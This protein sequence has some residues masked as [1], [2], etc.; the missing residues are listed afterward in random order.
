A[1]PEGWWRK[2][3]P[4]LRGERRVAAAAGSWME[5]CDQVVFELTGATDPA[6][7]RRSRCA[8][9]HKAMWHQS[10]GG[11]PPAKFLSRLDPRLG[12]L[13]ERLYRDT[14]TSDQPAGTLSAGWAAKLG[15][16][17]NTIVAM[18]LVDAHAG[19]VGGKISPRTLVKVM[20]T[21]TCDMM[22]AG[23][24]EI[25]QHLVKGICG[26]VD[27][28]VVPGMVGLEAGQ[29]GFGDLLAWFKDLVTEPALGLIK[30]SGLLDEGTRKALEEEV[31]EGILEKLSRAAVKI[32]VLETAPVALDWIHGRR[33]PD[34]NP[35]LKAALMG[36][37]AGTDAAWIY[38][39]LVES[40]CFGSRKIIERLREEGMSIEAVIAMGGVAQKSR[41][42]MQTMADVLG[43]P[44]KV[45]SSDQAPALGA[46]IFGAV[47]SG[48][49]PNTPSAIAAMGADFDRVYEPDST[50]AEVYEKLYRRYLEFGTFVEGS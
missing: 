48:I 10:W 34:A 3:L 18:G 39:A 2:S 40:L 43:M 17:Q 7:F 9:G 27:G 14:Y 26:Q 21:S 23:Y 12:E 1:W 38:R 24:G 32:P 19:A 50:N 37:Q 47:A 36:L 8:A 44:I 41:L 22:V 30:E 4:V 35:S 6:S 28:S 13:R 11:L 42:V 15:L 25:G 46:A 5:D 29:A 16:H 20:G 31:R 49:Y 45:S 33:T